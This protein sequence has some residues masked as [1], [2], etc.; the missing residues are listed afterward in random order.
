MG[1]SRMMQKAFQ[2]FKFMSFFVLMQS[3]R[4]QAPVPVA[5]GDA[6]PRIYISVGDPNVKKVLVAIEP[7]VGANPIADK[8][9]KTLNSDLR[10]TDLF[11]FL[12]V[13]KMPADKGGL[14]PGTFLVGPYKEIGADFLIKSGIKV[15]KGTLQAELRLYD[16]NRSAQIIGRLY[17][18]VTNAEDPARELA[19]YAGNDVVK[20]LTGQE[21]IFRTRILA[22]CGD[23]KKEVYIMDFDGENI[24]QLT[25]DGNLALSPSWAP[26]GKRILFTSYK[27]SVKGGFVNPNLYLY[28]TVTRQRRVLSAA[29]GLNTGGVF[30]PKENKVAYTFSTNGKPELFMHDLDANTRTALT[31]T[32]FFSV[33]PDFSPDGTQLAYSSS[34]TG[35][36]HIYVSNSDGQNAKRLTFAGIYNSSPRWS[37]AGNKIVFSGQENK[38]N[39][40]NIF[41]IDPSGSNLVRLTDGKSSSENPSWSPDGRYLAY[42]S[43]ADGKYRI[44]VMNAIGTNVRAITPTSLGLCKQP[45]WSPRL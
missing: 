37:P 44:Y 43:N 12:P 23:R 4:A 6:P 8:F 29:K 15:E 31:R 38:A 30:H 24:R 14:S 28:D 39:N 22:S 45:A 25:T 32:Q 41:M 17:P 20:A 11:E 42:S 9:L 2:I 21:G 36:P 3:V 7:T 33:E 18:L 10:F 13:D 5:S 27:P 1:I 16:V 35:R 40:F 19:H 26:D 34:K